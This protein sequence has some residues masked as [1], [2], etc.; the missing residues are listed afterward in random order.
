MSGKCCSR[1]MDWGRKYATMYIRETDHKATPE[2]MKEFIVVVYQ[3]DLNHPLM[4][5]VME[6]RKHTAILKFL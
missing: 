2:Q 3:A 1:F 4:E 5:E 6:Q